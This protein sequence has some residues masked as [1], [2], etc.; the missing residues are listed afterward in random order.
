MTRY[1]GYKDKSSKSGVMESLME[2]PYRSIEAPKIYGKVAIKDLLVRQ[3]P[4]GPVIEIVKE[5]TRLEILENL[6]SKWVQVTTPSG[7]TG[8]AGSQFIVREVE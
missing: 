1:R 3:N 2:N 6:D 4:T 5:G 8:V 7:F